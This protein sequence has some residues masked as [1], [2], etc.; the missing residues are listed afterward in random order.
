MLRRLMWIA[1][2]LW[3]CSWWVIYL[4]VF[5]WHH[6]TRSFVLSPPAVPPGF[7]PPQPGIFLLAARAISFAAPPA[8]LLLLL[9]FAV[10]KRR[11]RSASQ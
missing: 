3:V 5:R 7:P 9:A 2:A 1:G 10:A 11:I 8:F 4:E 6:M